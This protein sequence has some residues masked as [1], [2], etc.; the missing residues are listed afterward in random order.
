[1]TP[2]D[3]IVELTATNSRI[4]K[5][6]IV[7]KAWNEKNF[8]F[9]LGAQMAYDK[10]VT[11]GLAKIPE[12]DTD[13]SGP[14]VGNFTWT[15]FVNITDQL[16]KRTLT[17][18]AARATVMM[19][20]EKCN[21]HEWNNWY[22]RILRKDFKAGLSE[23]TINDVLKK[24][25]AAA[26]PY[27]VPVFACQLAKDAKE[28]PKKVKGKKLIDCK[29][30]GNRFLT[31]IDKDSN[32][33]EQYSRNGIINDNFKHLTDALK[34]I[35]PQLTESVVLDGEV[36]SNNFQAMMKQ[37]KRKNNPDTSDAYL[38]LFDIIPLAAFRAGVYSVGQRDRHLA[39]CELEPIIK[40]ATDNRVYVIPKIE[41]DLDTDEGKEKLK[42]FNREALFAKYEGIMMKDPSAP[43]Q[44]KRTDAWLKLKPTIQ[45]DLTI[46]D[47]EL[48]K[49]DGEH[50]HTMGNMICEGVDNG[51]KIRV[52]V[53]SGWSDELRE[54]IWQ[55]R[56]Q[57]IGR[58]VEIEAD[59][60]T[61]SE[62]NGDVYSLR[63]PRFVRFRG[64]KIGEKI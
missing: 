46:V 47:I 54:E 23:S 32:T 26:K 52:S 59:A 43:Y 49:P 44:C 18:N 48:G 6:A 36:V 33:V 25:G 3:I 55:N 22:R 50:A 10:L 13:D 38:A 8:E 41:I 57:V 40:A 60:L 2:A 24:N 5:E 62:D 31:I 1:M 61:L 12:I 37:F 7:Q 29:I 63:F 34:T 14:A 42:E 30:D 16:Q 58:I 4:E 45:V 11:F 51:Y 19:C 17:G 20:A 28:N 56:N 39:L 27:M 15:E 53:G 64:W 35:I 21:T 9:F